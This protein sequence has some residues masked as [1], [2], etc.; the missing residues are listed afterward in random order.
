[1]RERVHEVHATQVRHH[2]QIPRGRTERGIAEREL[3]ELRMLTKVLIV[4]QVPQKRP[5][6]REILLLPVRTPG[7]ESG[8]AR[9]ELGLLDL[10]QPAAAGQCLAQLAGR[11]GR[12][13]PIALVRINRR[14]TRSLESRNVGGGRFA[15][16]ADFAR[17][18]SP[19]G[20]PEEDPAG[21]RIA[22]PEVEALLRASQALEQ[23]PRALEPSPHLLA[24]PPDTAQGPMQ[25]DP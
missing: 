8:E 9:V 18:K 7:V 14:S 17:R 13:Q 24:R 16:M 10:E 25:R 1:M 21:L 15:A 20:G 12:E 5:F 6:P 22:Q 11:L 19:G 2:S 23:R 4:E 3:D